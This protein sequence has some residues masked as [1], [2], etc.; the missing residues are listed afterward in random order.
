MKK[1]ADS[2]PIDAA[3]A[4][5]PAAGG[6]QLGFKMVFALFVIFMLVVSDAFTN[7]VIGLFGGAVERR[8]PTAWGVVLQGIFLVLGF[9][10][11]D[12]LIGQGVL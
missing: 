6:Q 8:T 9:I 5:A 10:A 2:V 11:A 7:S 1:R 12:W 3:A 4:P